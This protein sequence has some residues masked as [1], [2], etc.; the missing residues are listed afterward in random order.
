MSIRVVVV[1]VAVFLSVLPGCN[2][3]S[4]PAPGATGPSW[5]K[6]TAEGVSCEVRGQGDSSSFAGQ[7]YHEF[8]AG[9]NKLRVQGGRVTANG[10]EYGSVKSG[11]SVLLDTD[12]TVS[13]NGE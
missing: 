9:K 5:A 12:G 7:D 10:K 1:A 2:V 3:S 8:T 13:I 11:D 6:G 4:G